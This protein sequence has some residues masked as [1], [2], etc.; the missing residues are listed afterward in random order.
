MLWRVIVELTIVLSASRNNTSQV[1]SD[2]AAVY[3]IDTDAIALEVKRKFAAKQKARTEKQTTNKA[4]PAT[5][6]KTA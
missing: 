2:G 6:K 1:L 5:V 4:V 3:E